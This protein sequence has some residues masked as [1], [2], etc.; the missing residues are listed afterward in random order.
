MHE[1]GSQTEPRPDLEPGSDSAAPVPGPRR[2]GLLRAAV[3][4]GGLAVA[5]GAVGTAMAADLLPGGVRL[6]RA[7]GLTGP[8]GTVPQVT[9]GPVHG[10]DLRSAARGRTVRMI[11]MLPPGGRPAAELPVC[12]V[13]HGRGGDA[14]AM[15]DLGLPQFLAAAAAGTAPFALVAVDGGDATYWHERTPGDD[16]QRMLRSE[17]PAALAAQGLRP[18]GAALGISMGGSGALRYARDRGTE[19]GPVALLS[20]ALF[21]SWPDARTVD[22]FRD[23]ADWREHEPLLHLDRP[24]GRPLGVWCGTEDPFCPAARTLTA[25][26]AV[27]RF[28]HG[29]HTEGFWRRVAPEVLSFLGL[30]LG[31]G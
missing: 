16:P 26:A 25:R 18:P 9:A 10:V 1:Q 3:G 17:L 24:H 14:Q 19:F 27:A 11:T 6:R 31:R 7:L 22:G 21:R 20:P 4:L 8:D 5:G 28:P 30:A 15:A 23:E 2:R 12:V 29:E 13:L